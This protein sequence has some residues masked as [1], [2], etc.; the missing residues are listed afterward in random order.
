MFEIF[1]PKRII[2]TINTC[3]GILSICEIH[4]H[5]GHFA[6]LLLGGGTCIWVG[7][8]RHVREEASHWAK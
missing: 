4:A 1:N 5:T 3:F 8:R 6:G 2:Y 7:E